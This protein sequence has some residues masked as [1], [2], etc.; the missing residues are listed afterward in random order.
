MVYGSLVNTGSAV[1]IEVQS[2]VKFAFRTEQYGI[3]LHLTGDME[4][5]G[6]VSDSE[7]VGPQDIA[8]A[9]GT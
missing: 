5:V 6:S 7:P 8:Y 4:S 2:M 3:L 1:N 9:E